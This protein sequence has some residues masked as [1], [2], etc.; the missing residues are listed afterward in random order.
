M[1]ISPTS[2]PVQGAPSAGETQQMPSL[3]E[4]SKELGTSVASLREQLEVAKALGFVDARPRTG[5]R[6]LPYTFLPAVRQSLFYAIRLDRAN[7]N[8]IAELRNHIESDF[9]DQSVR[10]LTFQDQQALQDL[11]A[12]AW[13]KLRGSPVQI[14]HAE[15]RQ[16][17]LLIYSRLNNPF[18]H[19]ILEA[20]RESYEAVRLALYADY[21][22][23]QDVWHYHQKMVD[24]ICQG[25]FTAGFKALNEHK[26]LLY[27]RSISASPDNKV[28]IFNHA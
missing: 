25:D 4:V 21:Y 1:G 14:P 7:F 9:G 8:A 17:H 20:Y 19:G 23:L 27:H 12:A 13:D 10:L 3:N 18:V 2:H 6:R 28:K 5:I 22:Y 16:L 26:D 15:H 11:V 24:A